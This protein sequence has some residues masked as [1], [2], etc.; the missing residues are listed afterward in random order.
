MATRI[1]IAIAVIL[2]LASL[3]PRSTAT[4]QSCAARPG[5]G[6]FWAEPGNGISM[7]D[8]VP[9]GEKWTVTAAGVTSEAN[10]NAEYMLM[11]A[12]R[13]VSAGGQCCWFIGLERPVGK[14]DGTPTIALGH[15]V[16]IL[17]GDRLAARVNGLQADKRIALNYLYWAMPVTCL[18]PTTYSMN[19]LQ[20]GG[21]RIT[22]AD[23][24]PARIQ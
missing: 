2:A 12:H 13:V 11:I 21:G 24:A 9:A 1:V 4:A 20:T 14:P 10:A 18:Q 16:T 15:E 3:Y 19:Y 7:G 5:E 8:E 6:N 23:L 17:P 22:A